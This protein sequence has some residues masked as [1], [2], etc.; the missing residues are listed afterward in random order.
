MRCLTLAEAL[1]DRGSRTRFVC[2]SHVGNLCELL[3]RRG[4]DVSALPAESANAPADGAYSDWLGVTQETDARDTIETFRGERPDWLIVDHYALDADWERRL[5]PYVGR[6]MVIDDLANRE[7][8]CAALLDQNDASNAAARYRPL[9]PDGCALI[10]GPRYAL[11]RPEYRQFRD[12]RRK[13]DGSVRR[14]LVF[15]GGTDPHDVTGMALDALST[16]ELAHLQ[17]DVVIGA[18][19]PHRGR[20]MQK[21][22]ARARTEPHGPRAHLADLLSES[23]LAIGAGGT[24]SWERLCL[25][26]PGLVVSIAANQEPICR[27]LAQAG[28]VRYLGAHTQVDAASIARNLREWIARPAELAEISVRAEVT[29]DGL[30]APRLAEYLDPTPA[31]ALRL[32]PAV[33]GDM[34]LYFA[35]ANDPEVRRQAIRTEEIALETHRRWFEIKLAAPESELF[36]MCA[37]DLPVGQ[38][39]FDREAGEARIDYSIDPL[40]RGRGWAAR[41]VALGMQGMQGH[42]PVSFRAEVKDRN[43]ASRAVF[44]RLG[45]TESASQGGDLV[46]YLY[47]PA[48]HAGVSTN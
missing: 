24:T 20:L 10:A 21:I 32:R 25:G 5:Q 36:V 41:L 37:G 27:D 13:R 39:R 44:R 46:T 48:D 18:N 6:I 16:G 34:A 17:V 35:W 14:V 30:G 15:F 1:R 42:G 45:Y 12:R 7:H 43:L 8:D 4:M 47:D 22:S 26:V 31:A 38:I 2:R 29:V 19:N 11:L 40:F 28:L 3:K 23:D 9:V 33:P